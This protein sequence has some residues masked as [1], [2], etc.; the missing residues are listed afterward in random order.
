[1]RRAYKILAWTAGVIVA[2]P[3]VAIGG[4]L[5]FANT[6][7]GQRM[8]E[9]KLPGLTGGMVRIEGLSGRV[10][11]KLRAGKIELRDKEGVWLTIEN[12][13][14][15]WHPLSL[16][17]KR[18]DID[19]ASAS[20]IAMPRLP[21]SEP[22]AQP[23]QPA[24]SEPSNYGLPVTVKLDKLS[25]A[26]LDLGAPVAGV[27][28]S[29]S[30]EG[31][32][33]YVSLDDLDANLALNRL[34]SPGTYELTGLAVTPN[35]VRGNLK[36]REPAHGF[37]GTLAALPD[38]G[39]L[40]IDANLDGPRSGV[41]TRLA[42]DAGPLT[43]RAD[44]TVD[45]VHSAADLTVKANAPQMAPR[46]DLT[47][48]SI[49]LDARVRGAWAAPD[50]NGTLAI[51][52][53]TASGAAIDRIDATVR[54]DTKQ[55]VLHAEANGVTV[56]G[57]KPDALA[58]APVVVD[59]TATLDQP[60]RPL[61]LS[62]QHPLV[63]AD[64]TA[65]TGGALRAEST[66]T[67]PNLGPL[68]AIGGLD[69]RGSTKLA[70]TARQDGEAIAFTAKGPLAITGGMAP[71]PGL[72]GDAGALDLA[73]TLNG[74]DVA[75]SRFTLDGK[76]L[77][78]AADG[79]LHSN[80]AD[81]TLRARLADLRALAPTVAGNL[82]ID[83]KVAGP[84][85]D[86][87]LNATMTGEVASQ[88]VPRGPLRAKI[89]AAHLPKAPAATVTA[90]GTLDGAP[91]DLAIKAAQQ[92]GGLKIDID[93]ANWKSAHAAGALTLPSGAKVPLGKLDLRMTRLDDLRALTG[94]PLTGSVTA[95]LET[96]EKAGKPQAVLKADIRNAG[97][98][99]T[100][101][102]GRANLA[103][104][105][106]D[107]TTKPVLDAKLT[108]DGV[109]A[110]GMSASGTVTAAGPQD[111]LG[112]KV[113]ANVQNVQ[114]APL[115]LT[116]A[117]TVDVP[118]SQTAL[119]QLQ[120]QWKGQTLRLLAPAR[121][122]YGKEIAVDRLRLGMQQ[123]TVD[124]A[125]RISPTLDVTASV[126]NVTPDLAKIAMPDLQADG[127]LNADARLT[128][129]TANPTGTVKVAATGLRMRT[130][131]FR[132]LPPASITANAE[133]H[134]SS[135]D[136]DARLA[137]GRGTSL[138]VN[139]RVP[140]QPTT[141]PMDVRAQ[142]AV[143]LALLNP[144]LEADGRR[145]RGQMTLDARALGT[146]AVPQVSGTV[147]L[148]G[149]EVQDFGLGLRIRDIAA[150]IEAD[151]QT[152]R[153]SRFTGRAGPGTLGL[154]GTVSP[155][156]PGMP[157]DL[158]FVANNAE[159]LASDRLTA[160]MSADLTV[161]GE[162]QNQLAARG[163]VTISRAEIRVPEH[164]PVS[165][166]SL[167]VRRPGDKPEPP[168]A[169][170]PNVALDVTVTA[171]NQIFVRGQ[172]I[173]AELG[174]TI[175]L[176]GTSNNPQP[177]G[178]FNLIRGTISVAGQSLT[179][180][181]GEVSFNGG[182]LSDP[183]ILFVASSSN[184]TMTANLEVSGTASAPKIRLY[185]TPEYPQDEVLAQL[186]FKRSASSLSPFE[187]AQLAAALA[188]LTGVTGGGG[189]DPLNMVREGLG[190]DTLSVGGGTGNS[191]PSL[192]GG[193]YVS[194]GVFVGAKQGTGSGSTQ[195]LVQVDLYKGLKLQ[196]TVGSGSNTNPG[197][198]P[199]DS[200]GSS[201][202]LKYQFEY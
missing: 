146:Y 56:P 119:S 110:S 113:A 173:F 178:A 57:P 104:T 143:D 66:V 188:Q 130:G 164:M 94:K 133:L 162:I 161:S 97:L 14:L 177:Q 126:R 24:S 82:A 55:A 60:S 122:S 136:V 181:K 157:V 98:A 25:V 166:V 183:S 128:G 154:T 124:V 151:G 109:A 137:A 8:I 61:T 139:G 197:A 75:V 17:G 86:F 106:L 46:P 48:Q 187:L 114:G 28:G 78:L 54:G 201:I 186:I 141:G 200:A 4:V 120:A 116:T 89:E 92:S 152:I 12:L 20:L 148:S 117:A 169:P 83:A 40:S 189:F 99:G 127:T 22:A 76:T 142:G 69:I 159:P 64:G 138:T 23:A 180:T 84:L 93:R 47:W 170:G 9:D 29:F 149:G 103:A 33:R 37:V 19:L 147:Q 107:P 15:D 96:A 62:I 50:A 195:G 91:L 7:A 185:S 123:A 163:R 144:I 100:A 168:P 191:G 165:I 192:T 140:V 44:G 88:G 102:V 199:E 51:A 129:T 53:L 202:G 36:V 30:A 160:N 21:V 118:G 176:T 190:L 65:E 135:A 79:G 72:I 73:G 158:H 18:A 13:A 70:L 11:D 63:Q 125:G 77:S 193:R 2:V 58:G 90:E 39:P 26:K 80:V 105:I 85:D 101:T 155:T 16:L 42:L 121:I 71:L 34:D 1:M 150:L 74:A 131:Q 45:L 175:H 112:V 194:P 167:D 43:A 132:S 59:V 10:P 35:A 179:F 6:G 134:G 68:A 67:V 3:I 27:A 87:G 174:G 198:S 41:S 38:L 49:A 95:S 171:P 81:V 156:A 172:G 32:A 196:G 31:S 145:L 111:A 5:I 184:S 52:K 108:A 153:I 115:A 182:K